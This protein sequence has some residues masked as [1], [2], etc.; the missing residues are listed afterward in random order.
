MAAF[1]G[2]D[3]FPQQFIDQNGII[4]AEVSVLSGQRKEVIAEFHSPA[5]IVPQK[6]KRRAFFYFSISQL[7]LMEQVGKL[8]RSYTFKFNGPGAPAVLMGFIE[9][10]RIE[11]F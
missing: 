5:K 9:L 2:E 3:P 6:A 11:H 4:Q 8:I 10:H 1:K 7:Y